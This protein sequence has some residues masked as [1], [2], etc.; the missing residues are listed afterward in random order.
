MT[1]G[2]VDE[3][4]MKIATRTITIMARFT[5]FHL[6]CTSDYNESSLCWLALSVILAV[7]SMQLQ[8]GESKLYLARF[9]SLLFVH[10]NDLSIVVYV[11]VNEREVLLII[12]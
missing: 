1:R 9:G 12:I 5:R 6:P 10:I 4:R 7:A 3:V 2:S 8:N 11:Y